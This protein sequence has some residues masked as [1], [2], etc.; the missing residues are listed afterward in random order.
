MLFLR[1]HL[2]GRS[3]ETSQSSGACELCPKITAK[4][5]EL[6]GAAFGTWQMVGTHKTDHEL[7]TCLQL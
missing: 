6:I 1:V 3:T 5:M 4:A 7:Q 2:Y